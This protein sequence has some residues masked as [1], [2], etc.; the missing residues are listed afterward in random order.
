MNNKK[1]IARIANMDH[2]PTQKEWAEI[3]AEARTITQRNVTELL[4]KSRLTFKQANK[5]V[6]QKADV[7]FV[8]D[9]IGLG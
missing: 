3:H 2:R 4:H 5:I 7:Y 6:G 8:N 1:L 9:P